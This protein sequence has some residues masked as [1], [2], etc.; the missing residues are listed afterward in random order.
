LDDKRF[1][2]FKVIKKIGASAYK[3]QLPDN[4]PG[5]HPV[6]NESYLHPYKSPRYSKQQKPP[7]PPPVETEEGTRYVVEEI[8]DSR[9]HRRKLQYLVHWEGYPREEDTWEPEAT[10]KEDA[11]DD[12]DEFHAKNP[13]R[14]THADIPAPRSRN[15]RQVV[16]EDESDKYPQSKYPRI[17]DERTNTRGEG[18]HKPTMP[19]G[20]DMILPRTP[21]QVDMLLRKTDPEDALPPALPDDICRVW[22]YE[23][24]PVNA[25]TTVFYIGQHGPLR[26]YQ[27]LNPLTEIEIKRK[28]EYRIPTESRRAPPWLVC[29]YYRHRKRVW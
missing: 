24:A 29:D 1:G 17:Y 2:P 13:T 7:P 25:I 28:Y 10:M 9:I 4:W 26:C 15:V 8:R 20:V 12:V 11:P 27:L 18:F 23:L 5:I 21:E 16:M 14:P 22:I 6:F 19:T 3:L